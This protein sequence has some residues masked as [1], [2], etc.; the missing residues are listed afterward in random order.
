MKSLP[1]DETIK[2]WITK[3]GKEKVG[4]YLRDLLRNGND[5]DSL[6]WFVK[7]IK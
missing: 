3:V 4:I 7:H 5:E 2:K 1:K 6:M